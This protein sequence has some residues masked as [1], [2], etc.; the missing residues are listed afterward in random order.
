MSL[1]KATYSMVYGAPINV[2]DFGADPTGV[3]DST[4]AIQAAINSAPNQGS[5]NWQ[6][7]VVIIPAGKYKINS[8]VTIKNQQGGV[9]SAYGSRIEA[10][11]A[12]NAFQFGDTSGAN[13]NLWFTVEGL[14][15]NQASTSL[16]ANC[17][18]AEHNYSCTFRDCFFSG[19]QYS[20]LLDGNAN[21][22]QRTTFRSGITANVLTATTA[23]NE[24]N[25]FQEC[26]FELSSNFGLDLQVNAGVGG[27]TEVLNCYFE[28]NTTANIRAKNTNMFRIAGCYFNLQNNATGVLLDGTVGSAFPDGYGV[29]ENNRILGHASL[30]PAFI[31]EASS[32]SINCSYKNNQVESGNCSLYASAPRSVNLT[33]RKDMA[34]VV[35][36]DSFAGGSPPTGWTVVNGPVSTSTNISP[37]GSAASLVVPPNGYAYQTIYVPS[38]ALMRFSVWAQAVSTGTAA[39]QIWSSGLVANLKSTSSSSTSAS[40]LE[41]YLSSMERSS[42]TSV[43]ML[44]RNT[45][46]ANV[47][48]SN[49]VIEDMTN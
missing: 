14:T 29:I 12:G 21:L 16:A 18:V 7:W 6:P 27:G 11:F 1:T 33:R 49:I 47:S 28:A 5:P 35:N 15:V 26:A 37:Y 24:V 39:L 17:V 45:G 40:R 9:L 3:A 36:G 44:L 32:T 30:T 23:N 46:S 19:G 22:V 8:T 20:F 25:L 48:F 43:L 41:L 4:A 10:D 31:S 34:Y 13:D 38:D 2:L 42:A